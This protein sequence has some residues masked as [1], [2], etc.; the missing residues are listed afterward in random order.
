MGKIAKPVNSKL[1]PYS[2]LRDELTIVN[3]LILKGSKIVIP[4]TLIKEIKQ[5]LHTGHLGFERTRSNARSTML[6][7]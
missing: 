4:S 5:I 1:K 2:D 3:N 6:Q 7:Y